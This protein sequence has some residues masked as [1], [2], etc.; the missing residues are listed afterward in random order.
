MSNDA[1]VTI[2]PTTAIE[3]GVGLRELRRPTSLRRLASR[4]RS[5][6]GLLMLSKSQ[7]DRYEKGEVQPAPPLEY[8]EHLDALYGGGGWVELSIRNL[9]RPRWNPWLQEHGVA[10]RIH[11]GRW[12]AQFGG[13]VWIKVKPLPEC[14]N[15]MH[16][17][18]LEWGPWGRSI[19]T[20][21]A[22]DGVVLATGKGRDPDGI[23]R[24]CNLTVDH[25]VFA[26]YGSGESLDDESVI[27]IRRGWAKVNEDATE[28]ERGYGPERLD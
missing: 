24:I 13:L 22:A 1:G 23:S 20:N 6:P 21:I 4:Q 27:D 16:R 28:D 7:L 5:G 11:A 14:A 12:P 18:F 15:E 26:L 19:E 3:L 2:T 8:A 9:W 17:M 10:A 25:D